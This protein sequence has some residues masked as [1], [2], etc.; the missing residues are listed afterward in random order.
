ATITWTNIAG[1]NWSSP[2]NWS[3]NQVPGASD[4]V[5]ITAAGTYTVVMDVGT[6]VASLTVGAGG[7]PSGVQTLGITNNTV[8]VTP[9]TVA[10]GG[11]VAARGATFHGSATVGSAGVWNYFNSIS[12]IGP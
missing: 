3:P 2:A 5:L 11:L 9:L 1:G 10:A 4:N 7:G 12:Y 8:F 6:T